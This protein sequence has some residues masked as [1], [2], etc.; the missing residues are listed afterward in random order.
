MQ[1]KDIS[2]AAIFLMGMVMISTICPLFQ[3]SVISS[4]IE[5]ITDTTGPNI[6][7][8]PF[9]ENKGENPGCK[10][11]WNEKLDK[12]PDIKVGNDG[13]LSGGFPMDITLSGEHDFRS[14][15]I[16][17]KGILKIPSFET[18]RIRANII[19]VHE[20]GEIS[21]PSAIL[22]FV[23]HTIIING[24]VS[25]DGSDG[26]YIEPGLTRGYEANEDKK[27]ASGGIGGGEKG[28]DD[29]WGGVDAGGGGGGGYGGEG[30]AGGGYVEGENSSKGGITYG[31]DTGSDIQSGSGGGNGGTNGMLSGGWGGNGGGVIN[32][33]ASDIE[34][35]GKVSA[36]GGWG[37]SGEHLTTGT[38]GGGGS[39]GGILLNSDSIVL[40]KS[41][42]IKAEGGRGG[43]GYKG[44]PDRQ[45]GGGGGGG[46][47][48]KVLGNLTKLGTVSVERGD[49]E[50]SG[51]ESGK[52]GTIYIEDVN[53]PPFPPRLESPESDTWV[54]V[55]PTLVWFFRDP[56]WDDIQYGYEIQL[57]TN[58]SFLYVN[59]S[60]EDN[61]SNRSSWTPETPMEE[62]T[63]YWRVRTKDILIW[64]EY[65]KV[66]CIKVEGDGDG[67]MGDND[68]FPEDPAA[69]LDSDEDGYPD[70]WNEGMNRT[71]STSMPQLELD[72]YPYNP[73]RWNGDDGGHGS[74]G[75]DDRGGT[76]AIVISMI[77]VVLVIIVIVV[78]VVFLMRRKT[79]AVSAEQETQPQ[80]LPLP[81]QQAQQQAK[82]HPQPQQHPQQDEQQENYLQYPYDEGER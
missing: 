48:I 6:I 19:V 2:L 63:W 65:S 34:I 17:P 7:E 38:G 66:R 43:R 42:Y 60:L 31:N 4:E 12:Y 37:G 29:F 8:N 15:E 68:S 79:Q 70:E 57:S 35:T 44:D 64:S 26:E 81:Q 9:K 58:S 67:M 75:S 55:T 74:S 72:A 82:Q 53:T 69:S 59:I 77:I 18:L 23:A 16:F 76:S 80:P 5:S 20:E 3:M 47:R 32:Y 36:N 62:R 11:P 25:V 33:T 71:D 56:E 40:M 30:G 1:R 28:D 52:Q 54:D 61:N 51:G 27:G 45:A 41:G 21:G 50:R 10:I 13:G 73:D 78:I 49:G 14:V 24:G 22:E 46:G 39:G